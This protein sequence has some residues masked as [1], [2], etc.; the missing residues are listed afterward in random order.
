MVSTAQAV[1]LAPGGLIATTGA[2]SPG[3]TLLTSVTLPFSGIFGK[4]AG[5]V[6]QYVRQNSTGILFE[7]VIIGTGTG[8]TQATAS[9]YDSFITD[10]DGPISPY[11]PH[12]D[13]VSRSL[14]GE[15]VTF[16]YLDDAILSPNNNSGI[17]W[18]Q[19]NAVGYTTGGFSVIGADSST[20]SMFGPSA[21][22]EPGTMALMGF[23]LIGG[24][25]ARRRRKVTA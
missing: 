10:V 7:Y 14:D 5:T 11:L 8:I 20:L 23:G 15:T 12:A 3:G 1:P 4:I 21:V 18:I 22:P 13:A 24:I 6:T 16:S 9:F 2:A 19:T 25:F 17:L